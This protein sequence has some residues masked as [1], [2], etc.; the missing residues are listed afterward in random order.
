M[1]GPGSRTQVATS[2]RERISEAGDSR[3]GLRATGDLL[4]SEFPEREQGLEFPWWRSRYP[5]GKLDSAPGLVRQPPPP[6]PRLV[7]ETWGHQLRPLNSGCPSRT[8]VVFQD[9]TVIV[10]EVGGADKVCVNKIPL[11]S[12]VRLF[13]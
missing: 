7:S 4:P 5:F 13:V 10:C 11:G 9:W 2:G 12:P 6:P 3:R 8:V 1:G